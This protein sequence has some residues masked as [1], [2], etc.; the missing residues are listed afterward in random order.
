MI[1][2]AT[3]KIPGRVDLG[4]LQRLHE[5]NPVEREPFSASIGPKERIEVDDKY[6][7]LINIQNSL[8]RE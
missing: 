2:T 6:Y 7:T 1:I 8:G 4:S 3:N 5:D